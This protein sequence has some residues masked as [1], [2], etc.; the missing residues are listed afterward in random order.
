[1][2]QPRS[3]NDDAGPL[4][5]DYNALANSIA[6]KTLQKKGQKP[7]SSPIGDNS[8][9][10]SNES[11][12]THE[13]PS[14]M[15]KTVNFPTT[16][17]SIGYLYN[18]GTKKFV[19][20]DSNDFIIFSSIEKK[21]PMHLYIATS[22]NRSTGTYQE[23]L[24]ASSPPTKSSRNYFVRNDQHFGTKRL[25]VSGGKYK[26]AVNLYFTST[27]ANRFV[28]TPPYYK[29]ESAFKIRISTGCL[30]VDR[31]NNLVKGQCVDDEDGTPTDE[32]NRQLFEF[33]PANS[34][35][36]CM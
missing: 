24:S 18:V 10:P 19:A 30:T 12:D 29:N 11:S 3:S 27:V 23:I 14:K 7:S 1:M 8:Y 31:N 16:T 9:K 5:S 28:I 6:N 4:F 26:N 32:N 35:D 20:K 33:C 25:N 34:I 36:E 22:F 21:R 17:P 2:Y 13:Y 15:K